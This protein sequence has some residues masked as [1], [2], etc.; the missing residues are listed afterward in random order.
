M[1]TNRDRK[2]FES[3]PKIPKFAQTTGT[4]DVFLS[5]IQAFRDPLCRELPHFQIFM[6]DGPNPLTRDAQVLSY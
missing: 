6:N 4:A 5:G 3:R 1:I 2:S